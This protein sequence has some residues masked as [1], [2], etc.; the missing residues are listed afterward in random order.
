M[1]NY[2]VDRTLTG[3]FTN[4]LRFFFA[5]LGTE[6]SNPDNSESFPNYTQIILKSRTFNPSIGEATWCQGN[7]KYGLAYPRVFL[8]ETSIF[9]PF[10]Y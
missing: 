5:P 3:L 4:N 2:S 7:K 1:S 8:L 10:F 9:N 6:I